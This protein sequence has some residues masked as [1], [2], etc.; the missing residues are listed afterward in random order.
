MYGKYMKAFD[1]HF[2]IF[3]FYFHPFCFRSAFLT[4]LGDTGNR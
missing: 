2:V 4:Q 3:N 1:L